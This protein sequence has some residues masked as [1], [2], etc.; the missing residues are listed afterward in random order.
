MTNL[1]QR[2]GHW[3]LSDDLYATPRLRGIY[4][5]LQFVV[6]LHPD[7][8][9]H[10]D[11]SPLGVVSGDGLP[12]ECI[13]AFGTYLHETIHWWQHVGS[14]TGLMLSFAY[15]AQAHVNYR[16]LVTLLNRIGLHKSLRTYLDVHHDA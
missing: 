3:S 7:L 15:P 13:D 1:M 2:H 4:H 12:P 16:H 8:R 5:P 9:Q 11:E 14:T 6:R 10:L